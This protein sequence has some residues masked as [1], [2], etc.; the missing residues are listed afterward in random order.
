MDVLSEDELNDDEP[1][2]DELND[3]EPREDV[4]ELVGMVLEH[5]AANFDPEEVE[6]REDD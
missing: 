6:S 4:I 1:R 3:D 2:E 5:H